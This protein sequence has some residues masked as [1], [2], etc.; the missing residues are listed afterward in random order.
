MSLK[1]HLSNQKVIK[2]YNKVTA[3]SENRPIIYSDAFISG[4]SEILQNDVK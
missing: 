1:G 2:G 4:E 3:I